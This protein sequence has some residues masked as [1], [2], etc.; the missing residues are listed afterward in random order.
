MTAL[1]LIATTWSP[2]RPR[3]ASTSHGTAAPNSVAQ[4]FLVNVGVL[5]V[6]TP[7]EPSTVQGST[8][9]WYFFDH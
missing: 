1:I 8:S 9:F 6:T 5:A 2:C 7:Q 3:S 4:P